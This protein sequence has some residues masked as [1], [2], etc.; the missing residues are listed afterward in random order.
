MLNPYRLG[1]DRIFSP[2]ITTVLKCECYCV[3]VDKARY[4]ARVAGA[5]AI[6]EA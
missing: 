1:R 5:I 6:L 2:D 3:F 4:S